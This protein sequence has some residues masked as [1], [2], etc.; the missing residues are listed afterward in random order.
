MKPTQ[1]NTDTKKAPPS[2]SSGWM[3]TGND[4]ARE[5][6][7]NKAESAS[8]MVPSFWLIDGETKQVRFLS[9]KP[10]ASIYRYSFQSKGKWRKF[11]MPAPG[12][13]DLFAKKGLSPFLVC[14]YEIIDVTGYLD[15]NKKRVKNT[16]KFWEVGMRI[17]SSLEKIN[18]KCGGLTKRNLEVSREGEG[19]KATYTFIPE[20]KSPMPV[21]LERDPL[22]VRFAE[23]FAPPSTERQSR[24]LGVEADD[25]SEE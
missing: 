10:I 12:E 8:S 6:K 21:P 20:D 5:I 7:R 24:I 25:T 17:Q 14:V 13:P 18:E 11:T 16:R 15:K 1:K 3:Q 9:D 4:I 19:T 2:A 22:T 23:F